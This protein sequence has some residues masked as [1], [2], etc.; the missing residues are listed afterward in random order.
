MIFIKLL[1]YTT[2]LT[3]CSCSLVNTPSRDYYQNKKMIKH[4]LSIDQ[5]P[6]AKKTPI[7]LEQVRI[8]RG[9]IVYKENCLSC[10][11]QNARG[12]PLNKNGM[13]PKDL[14]AIAKKVQHFKF[15]MMASQWTK[16]MPGWKKLL[17][18]E[19][20]SDLEQYILY[21]AEKS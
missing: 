16:S 12:Y 11:G 6:A 2:I 13:M 9:K 19:E 15:F 17:T 21:L 20:I 1:I 10:H 8:D 3:L 7:K 5:V 4:G 18:K 14:V